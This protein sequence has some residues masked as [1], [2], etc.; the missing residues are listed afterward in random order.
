MEFFWGN[1]RFELTDKGLHQAKLWLDRYD[2]DPTED[3]TQKIEEALQ[4]ASMII[5]I[6]SPNWVQR[7]WCVKEINRFVELHSPD[8]I[9]L[10]QKMEPLAAAV[11]VPL[12][13][14]QGYSFYTKDATGQVRE[15]YWRGVRDEEAY[16][17]VIKRIA[18][19]IADRFMSNSAPAK[20]EAVPTGEVVYLAAATDELRDARK[21]IAN[22]LEGAGYVVCPSD[23]SA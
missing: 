15:F 13:N 9:V 16:N 8:E 1:L 17:G 20:V 6:L 18:L 5:T 12:R 11:P 14:R 23:E 3:F 2:I 19:W 21:R 4:E 7:P 10:V 22:D